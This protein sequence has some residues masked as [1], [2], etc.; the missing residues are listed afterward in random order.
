MPT[1]RHRSFHAR[2]W[3]GKETRLGGLMAA[4][5]FFLGVGFSAHAEQTWTTLTNPVEVTA[6]LSGKAFII[7]KRQEIYYREDGNVAE[8]D[9]LYE[10]MSLR[11]WKVRE[12]GVVCRYVFSKPDHQIDCLTISKADGREGVYLMRWLE[13]EAYPFELLEDIPKSLEQALVENAGA[14]D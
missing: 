4:A 10:S 8:F 3:A 14:L 7:K 12:D 9:P 1:T 13:A 6:T 2:Y 5:L 11:K